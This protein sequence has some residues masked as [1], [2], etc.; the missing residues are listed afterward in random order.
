MIIMPHMIPRIPAIA[1]IPNA[2]KD[3]RAPIAATSKPPSRTNIPAISD[4]MKAA[5]G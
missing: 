3:K 2:K 5:E 1:P 4:K